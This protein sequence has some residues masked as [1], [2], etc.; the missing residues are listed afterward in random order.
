[1]TA[2]SGDQEQWTLRPPGGGR[3]SKRKAPWKPHLAR[4]VAAGLCW[5]LAAG[6]PARAQEPAP[7]PSDAVFGEEI[8]VRVVNLEVVVEDRDGE[9]V[10][11]LQR[12]DFRILVDGEEVDVDYFTEV[13]HGR[14]RSGRDGTPPA[15][16]EGGTV[17]TNYVLF[18][19]DDHT[20]VAYRRP[21][22]RGFG[23][24][25][26]DLSPEDRVAVVVQSRNRL[27]LLSPFTEDR[28][29]TRAAIA[30]LESGRRFGGVLRSRRF[31]GDFLG[32]G[33]ATSVGGL[34]VR[35]VPGAA[36]VPAATGRSDVPIDRAEIVDRGVADTLAEANLRSTDGTPS[37]RI[38]SAGLLLE[39]MNPGSFADEAVGSLLERDL[40][41]AVNAVI[42]A[43]RA[44]EQPVGRRVLLLLAGQWPAG[45]F[46]PGGRGSALRTD[47]DLLDGLIDTAN[48][49]GY[50]LYP[51]DQQASAPDMRWWQ[52][53]RYMARDTGGKAFMA[54]SNVDA[55]ERVNDDTSDYYW[56]GFVPEYRR[57]DRVHD[58]EVEVLRPGLQVRARRGYVDLSRRAEADME[59]QLAL[60]FPGQR[61]A[62]AT[63]LQVRAGTPR[64]LSRRMMAV[65]IDIEVPLD[66][67]PALPYGNEYLQRL[68]V[69]F[70]TI[71]DA[72]WRAEQ[73]AIPLEVRSHSAPAPDTVFDYYA[74]VTLRHLPHTVVV[75]V[76]DP[77]SRQ[78]ASAR[79]E[80]V[81]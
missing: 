18:V 65:P 20:Q 39:R 51:M 68:E 62:A 60:L 56:L 55:L 14:T 29:A 16:G 74:E 71:D 19:D 21:L 28:D 24:G 3:M 57:D 42:S 35:R 69:R 61:E 7:P 53:L 22:L 64:R 46:Q 37:D 79:L 15:V 17:A 33:T 13:A 41:L 10:P 78:T 76:H 12:D 1:M 75:T 66:L 50:T 77:V 80:V 81:P 47:L 40:S 67:F 52:N 36:S 34:A 2:A 9:R 54:G 23:D 4:A 27:E 44:L 6:T 70:A 49:L 31:H 30:E 38:A 59:A 5:A 58:V 72:G 63:V 48:L 25:L 8:D 26:A 43:M 11:G 45:E 73:P 32:G